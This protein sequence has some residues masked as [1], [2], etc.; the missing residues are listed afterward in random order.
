MKKLYNILIVSLMVSSIGFYSCE[1]VELERV[2]D[3]N[4]LSS[5]QADPNLL[6]NSIQLA[7]VQNQTVFNNNSADLARIDYM[8]GRNY[9][10]NY[11]SGNFKCS[12]DSFL[13]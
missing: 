12:L 11:D 10:E 8:F 5:D 13:Q 9:T 3:P 6:L 2:I 4:A 1:T 7:Y